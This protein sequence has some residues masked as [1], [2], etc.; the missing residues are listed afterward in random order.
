MIV[1]NP[2]E[3]PEPP[4]L[5]AVQQAPEVN[6]PKPRWDLRLERVPH[7]HEGQSPAQLRA[8]RQSCKTALEL[9]VGIIARSL[10]Q[11]GLGRAPVTLAQST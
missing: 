6:A 11:G 3:R 8:A 2:R 4:G 9:C 7:N 1:R 5:V 10:A